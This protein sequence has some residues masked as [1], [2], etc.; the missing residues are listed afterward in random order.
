[1]NDKQRKYHDLIERV[2]NSYPSRDL[3][4]DGQKLR[5]YWCDDCKEINLWTYWQGRGNLDAKIMLV[6]QDW[7]CPWDPNYQPTMEQIRKAKTNRLP[8]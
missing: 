6:G 2:K 7:G 8:I 4:D 5:L 3:A 1:M